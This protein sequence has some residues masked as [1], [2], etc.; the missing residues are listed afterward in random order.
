MHGQDHLDINSTKEET[1]LMW[2]A[3]LA[4][5]SRNLESKGDTYIVKNEQIRSVT[6]YRSSMID[7]TF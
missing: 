2:A 5:A 3:G 7:S 6:R 4:P 1:N